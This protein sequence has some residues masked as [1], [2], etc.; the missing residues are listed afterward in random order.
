MSV[1]WPCFSMLSCCCMTA[2]R[3]IN[4]HDDTQKYT[5]VC[6]KQAH[7]R[8][9]CKSVLNI[10]LYV[11]LKKKRRKIHSLVFHRYVYVAYIASVWICMYSYSPY[12]HWF[13]SPVI[14]STQFY[15]NI[16]IFYSDFSMSLGIWT[17]E[18]P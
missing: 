15:W 4:R 5:S 1:Q 17:D 10:C 6:K 2:K 18:Q 14:Q 13:R 9:T 16:L 7:D 12:A 3:I 8:H 11:F